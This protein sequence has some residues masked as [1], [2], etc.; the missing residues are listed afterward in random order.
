MEEDI[1]ILEEF[2]EY[3]KDIINDMEY[4]RPIDVTITVDD[5]QAIENLINR[6]K[7]L[8]EI[9]KAHQEENG[10]LREKVKEL[11]EENR[12]ILNSKVG[13]DLSYDDY[14]PKSVIKE[15]IEELKPYIYQG[16]NAPQDFL[17]YRV[18]AKIQVL[19]ELLEGRK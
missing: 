8:E 13:V 7:E 11:E 1:E 19:Q 17:Q 14:I 18:K 15:K 12:I 2:I 16:E 9:E 5:I 4:V 10:K 6:N 3:S